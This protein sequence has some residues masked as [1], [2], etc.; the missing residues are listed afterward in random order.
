MDEDALTGQAGIDFSSPLS[1]L[2]N[3]RY[4]STQLS[5]LF[6][7]EFNLRAFFLFFF[8]QPISQILASDITGY[9]ALIA[10]LMCLFI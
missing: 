9:C 10:A 3:P 7:T 6:A 2:Y 5:M 8:W 4:T 1:L